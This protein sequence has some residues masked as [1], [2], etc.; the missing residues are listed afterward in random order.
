MRIKNQLFIMFAL[1]ILPFLGTAGLTLSSA[2]ANRRTI[3]RIEGEILANTEAYYRFRHDV[4]II[5]Q[6]YTEVA[7]K[8]SPAALMA[9]TARAEEYGRDAERLV[10]SWAANL[11][12]AQGASPGSDAAS[13]ASS[14]TKDLDLRSRVRDYVRLGEAMAKAYVLGSEASAAPLLKSFDDASEEFSSGIDRL[15]KAKAYELQAALEGLTERLRLESLVTLAL[16][17]VS[18][19]V[20]IG[21]A[22]GYSRFLSRRLAAMV[23][24]TAQIKAGRLVADFGKAGKDELG[25]LSADLSEALGRIRSVFDEI[26]ATFQASR[27]GGTELFAGVDKTA[28]AVE[29]ITASIESM[30]GR[31]AALAAGIDGASAAS[32]EISASIDNL[33]RE[34]G[35]QADE[36]ARLSAATEQV[37]ASIQAQNAAMTFIRRCAFGKIR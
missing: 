37:S 36:V 16:V 21:L 26:G 25:L 22:L 6:A 3:A 18:A 29:Q 2:T 15:L 14:D 17:A 9:A 4:A 11:A 27:E 33:D 32:E 34:L 20:A 12:A 8:R 1:C 7:A 23:K 35:H 30:R 28:S 31:F 13:A 24:A 19:L 10:A 5:Q